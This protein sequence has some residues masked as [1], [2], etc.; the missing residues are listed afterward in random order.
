VSQLYSMRK[1][2]EHIYVLIPTLLLGGIILVIPQLDN[3]ELM[4]PTQ[5]G[6][7][8]G[9]LWAMLGYLVVILLFAALKHENLRI[10]VTIID[11]LL[12]AYGLMTAFSY[13]RHPIDQLQMLS[14]GA[15]VLFYLCVRAVNRRYLILL[16]VAVVI[17]GTIQAIYGNLQ[18]WGYYPS[19]H[20]IFRMTGSFFNPGPYAGY[21]AAIIPVSLGL[22]LLNIP[23]RFPDQS[24]FFLK[25][26]SYFNYSKSFFEKILSK[27]HFFYNNS[28]E[29]SR[30]EKQKSSSRL[31]GYFTMKSIFL[32]S[33]ICM[34]LVLPASRSRA[35]WLA[36]IAGSLF[37]F[38][39]FK[40][41]NIQTF[42][43]T[44]KQFKRGL[45]ATGILL[46]VLALVGI[47]KFKQDS[48][49]GRL[50]IWKVSTEM[51]KDK[52]IFGH[53]SGKFA[54][55]YMNYQAAYFKPNPDV[56]EAM[57][58]DNVTYAY[59]EFLKLAVEKGVIGL[60]IGLALV[61]C[62]FFGKISKKGRRQK[63]S[64]Q[65]ADSRNNILDN[66]YTQP[67]KESKDQNECEILPRSG[68]KSP[69]VPV[70]NS[71]EDLG[72]LSQENH[73]FNT[74]FILLAARG[75]LLSI[76]IFSLFSY[77]SEILPIKMLFVLFVAIASSHLSTIKIFQLPTQKAAFVSKAVCYS[78]ITI[79]L[80]IVYPSMKY[81][82]KQYQA[83][84]TWKDASDIYN[85]GAYPECLEDF[86][87]AYPLLKTNGIFLVQY[88]KALEMAKKHDSSIT[89]LNEAKQY[90]NNTILYTC[91]GNNYKDLGKNID[92]EQAYLQAWNIAPARFYPLYLL[93]KLYDETGQY[94]K[95]VE[96]A[97]K[98]LG[99]EIKIESTAIN[100]IQEEMRLI[101]KKNR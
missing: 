9:L 95:G 35:A 4:D 61:W 62:L 17:S 20:G 19:N 21:L 28:R 12:A 32:I 40:H 81:L 77:P 99:K 33:I 56:P 101:I 31:S 73:L 22:Y 58:A 60:L 83:Y 72:V 79:V 46:F 70:P 3:R 37:V 41:S 49:D 10:R 97:N 91:L 100:E 87:Q 7:A 82:T 65:L 15:L 89:I 68:S 80:L 30:Q 76:L 50:L 1:L 93:A 26:Y 86:E 5:S 38:Q 23:I 27:T 75:G 51:I 67:L 42:F 13:W 18:L 84:K 8:F 98:V 64:S 44:F 16:L 90:L 66:D 45:I 2:L 48:A 53:G 94:E 14:F 59:N 63:F 25:L 85:V 39:T 74:N 96:M 47:Y 57:Q 92:A 71:R 24:P 6:K 52:P 78:S 54:A 36:A 55:N 69:L 34:C 88:G 43:K 29:K 11:L